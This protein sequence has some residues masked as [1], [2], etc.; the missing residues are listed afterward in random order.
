M[1]WWIFLNNKTYVNVTTDKTKKGKDFYPRNGFSARN[2]RRIVVRK[3]IT[4]KNENGTVIKTYPNLDKGLINRPTR[5]IRNLSKRSN[6]PH[7]ANITLS[8]FDSE[9]KLRYISS[10]FLS[11]TGKTIDNFFK[12]LFSR[13]SFSGVHEISIS[14]L[15]L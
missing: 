10:G 6:N 5:A 13:Y 11:L 4:R 9:K 1:G 7:A 15:S 3:E 8:Y 12:Q 14:I 2:S